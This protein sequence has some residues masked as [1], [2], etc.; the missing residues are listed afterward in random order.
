VA[1]ARGSSDMSAVTRLQLQLEVLEWERARERGGEARPSKWRRGWDKGE[2]EMKYLRAL[3]G[4]SG[5]LGFRV[6][7][8]DPASRGLNPKGPSTPRGLRFASFCRFASFAGFCL[9]AGY[10]EHIL[11]LVSLVSVSLLGGLSVSLGLG[12][13]V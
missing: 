4:T 1:L 7:G 6:Q 10:R 12:F 11:Q 8:L 13:R 2:K 9:L 5:L 3:Q